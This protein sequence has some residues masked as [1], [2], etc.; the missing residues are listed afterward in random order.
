MNKMEGKRT[1]ITRRRS[2]SKA[3]MDPEPLHQVTFDVEMNSGCGDYL[4]GPT[5]SGMNIA[6]NSTFIRM[7]QNPSNVTIFG[8]SHNGKS[9]TKAF[10]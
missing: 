9:C 4:T 3:M 6:R 8:A 1:S 2:C 7:K 5:R 10:H